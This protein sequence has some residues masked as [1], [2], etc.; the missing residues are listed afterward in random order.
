M[1]FHVTDS[2]IADRYSDNQRAQ[3]AMNLTFF[4]WGIHG[5]IVYV[6]IGLLLS[7]LSYRKKLPMTMR[8]CFYPLLGDRVFGILGDIVDILSVVATMFGV[9]TSLG[10]GAIQLNSG[11]KRINNNIDI[12]TNNQIITIWGITAL[13]TASVI[14]GIKLGIRR[15]SE[16]CFAIGK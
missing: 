14:S 1:L 10:L 2:L 13:A 7:F 8:S 12:S 5:W 6:V 16:I 4:H 15:L 11:F 9:C 3:D